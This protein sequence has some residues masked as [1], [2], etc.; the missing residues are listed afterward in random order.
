MNRRDFHRRTASAAALA[1]A[2]APFTTRAVAPSTD[3]P[4]RFWAEAFD[5]VAEHHDAL[6]VAFD[7]PLPEALRGTL[8][9]NG[10]ARMRR[11]DTRYRHW[12]DGDGMVHAFRLHGRSLVHQARMVGTDKLRAEAV[13]GRFLRDGFGT[14]VAGSLPLSTPDDANVGNIAVLPLG[15]ELLALWEAGSPWRIDPTSLRTVGRKTWSA[16]SDRLAFS[17]HPRIDTDGTVWNFGYLTGS[18]K[19]A[20]WR[21]RPDGSLAA[22][23][24]IDAPNADMVHD[25]AITDRHLVFLLMPLRVDP[26]A[27]RES[28]FI[29]RLRWHDADPS[30]LL[31]VDKA[32]MA[33]S[34]R[35]ELPAMAFFHL[36]NAWRETDTVVLQVMTLGGLHATMEAIRAAMQG[37]PSQP[38]RSAMVEVRASL[39]EPRATAQVTPLQSAEFPAWDL[40]HTGRPT[41]HL[42]GVAAGPSLPAGAFGFNAIV[43]HD[44]DNGRIDR[45]DLGAGMLADEHLFVPQPRG[46]EGEGWV[47]GTAHDRLAERTVLSVY[48]AQSLADGPIS[49][50]VLPRRLPPGLHGRF[51]PAPA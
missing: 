21:L 24:L 34:H 2:A 37:R 36:G 44:R 20:L 1:L 3:S 49:Q 38:L 31:L 10:P 32:T 29:D 51:Q 9:R 4:N 16:V 14:T 33:V 42:V 45:H 11:G 7:R 17:A 26:Q 18:G 22:L 47:L 13:A 19:L 6:E 40:R 46:A 39:R 12:F 23:R 50:A 43:R 48:R 35:V 28:A 8:W 27:T 15:D 25:F 5:A 30:V 41:R